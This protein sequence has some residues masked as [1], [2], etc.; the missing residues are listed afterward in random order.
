LIQGWWFFAVSMGRLYFSL[1]QIACLT[2]DSWREHCNPFF[3]YILVS[4]GVHYSF[5]TSV[6]NRVCR[7]KLKESA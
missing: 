1:D 2:P 3:L 6:H 4:L 5:V 7:P